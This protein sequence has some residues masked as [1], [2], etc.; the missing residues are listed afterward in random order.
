MCA[1]IAPAEKEPFRGII[2]SV[3]QHLD[4]GCLQFFLI[5]PPDRQVWNDRNLAFQTRV[6]IRDGYANRLI[7][8]RI[9]EGNPERLRVYALRAS[10]SLSHVFEIEPIGKLLTH[11]FQVPPDRVPSGRDDRVTCRTLRSEE[12]RVGKEC[13]SRWSPYH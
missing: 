10:L 11:T 5:Q 6:R 4:G 12:R 1:D 13:R 8:V 9:W 3:W 7:I 2:L